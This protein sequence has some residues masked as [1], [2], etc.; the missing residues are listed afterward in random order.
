MKRY[1]IIFCMLFSS[2]HIGKKT[3]IFISLF[4]IPMFL[5][6]YYF[7]LMMLFYFQETSPVIG[8]STI[9]FLISSI[10]AFLLLRINGVSPIKILLVFVVLIIISRIM[11]IPTYIECNGCSPPDKDGMSV[12]T[13]KFCPTVPFMLTLPISISYNRNIIDIT[14]QQLVKQMIQGHIYLNEY[15]WRKHN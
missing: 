12:C 4:L 6:S 7:V 14:P 13:I 11:I 8:L 2:V 1:V 3:R 10:T 15:P 5:C 9:S